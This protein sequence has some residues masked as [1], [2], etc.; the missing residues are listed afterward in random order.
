M[1]TLLVYKRGRIHSTTLEICK[2]LGIKNKF[3]YPSFT[4]PSFFQNIQLLRNIITFMSAS[5]V[6]KKI[7]GQDIYF[8]EGLSCTGVLPYI[9]NKDNLIIARGNGQE[10][11]FM[12]KNPIWKYVYKKVINIDKNLDYMIAA[13]NM[14]KN[15]FK[16]YFNFKI[17]VAECFMDKD[18]NALKRIEPY[19]NSKNFIFIGNNPFLKGL[20]VMLDVFVDMKKRSILKENIKFYLIGTVDEFLEKKGYTDKILEKY[21]II[22]IGFTQNI[23]KYLE[24][25]L[26]QFHLARYEPN[27]VAVMEGMASGHIPIVSFKTG[28]KDFISKIDKNLIIHSFDKE[29]II[30]KVFEI[31]NY[32]ENKIKELSQKFKE[33][34]YIYSKEEGL[35]RWKE[36]WETITK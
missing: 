26:F 30:N 14:I 18:Y 27:A 7:K 11:F 25:S 12:E 15:D 34:S 8:F 33:E 35:K 6:A 10:I 9:K 31:V 29:K 22:K 28:N 20:D 3:E 24:K 32:D 2:V 4:L 19:F 21:N 13:S 23:E 17:E 1:N 36:V 5:N 16:K